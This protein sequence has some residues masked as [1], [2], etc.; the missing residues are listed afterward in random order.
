[1]FVLALVATP[2]VVTAATPSEPAV[3]TAAEAL[4]MVKQMA[5]PDGVELT[6]TVEHI[7]PPSQSAVKEA[8][9]GDHKEQFWGLGGLGFGGLGGLGGWGLGGWGNWGGWGGFGPYRYGFLCG[10][11]PGWAYPMGYW[12]M[13]GS[14]LYGGECS[15]DMA[16]GGFYYC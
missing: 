15:L 12:N 8:S 4:Q 9:E 5:L 3:K 13:F 2:T 6:G 16:F 1:M 7:D 11:I 14:G 10:G